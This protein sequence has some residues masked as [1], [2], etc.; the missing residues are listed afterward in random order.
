MTVSPALKADLAAVFERYAAD[1]GDADLQRVVA[2]LRRPQPRQRGRRVIDDTAAL[3][4]MRV[5]VDAGNAVETAA[6][7]VATASGAGQSI[8]ATTRRLARKFR[9]LGRGVSKV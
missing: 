9:A 6:G 8:E 5:L 7:F 3:A 2:A 4:E 1:T